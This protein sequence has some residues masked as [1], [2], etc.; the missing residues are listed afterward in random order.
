MTLLRY[1]EFYLNESLKQVFF[2]L[3]KR[4]R[5]L[6]KDCTLLRPHIHNPMLT[7]SQTFNDALATLTCFGTQ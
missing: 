2:L 7:N 3:T 4:L 6:N 1:F 5:Y